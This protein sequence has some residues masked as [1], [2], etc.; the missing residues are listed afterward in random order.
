MLYLHALSYSADHLS[1]FNHV[2]KPDYTPEP[3]QIRGYIVGE[4]GQ[5]IEFNL[6]TLVEKVKRQQKFGDD[7]VTIF[8]QGLPETNT[9]VQKASPSSRSRWSGA[10]RSQ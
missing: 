7:E 9:Q 10:V 6:N 4:R 2:F 8:I 3:S 5:K 1:Q